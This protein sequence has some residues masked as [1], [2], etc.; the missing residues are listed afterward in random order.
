M[1][2]IFIFTLVLSSLVITGCDIDLS[3]SNDSKNPPVVVDIVSGKSQVGT[4]KNYK[5]TREYGQ[6]TPALTERLIEKTTSN[7]EQA[8]PNDY[9]Y[10][11]PNGGPYIK[12]VTSYIGSSLILVAA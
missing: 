3:K 1:K 5:V 11:D 4:I 10:Q 2:R 12:I 6:S 9:S 7:I 8:L